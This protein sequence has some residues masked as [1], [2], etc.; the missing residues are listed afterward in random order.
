M[1]VNRRYQTVVIERA[2]DGPEEW[3][4]MFADGHIEVVATAH[5]ALRRVKR[6]ASKGNRGI[7]Y[8]NI[9]W[10]GVPDGWTPPEEV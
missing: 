6:A 3:M 1:K 2:A 4:V 8:T 5:E 9:S 10:R 7:T